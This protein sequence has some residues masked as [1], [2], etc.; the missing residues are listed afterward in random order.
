MADAFG[1]PGILAA[2]PLSAVFQILWSLLVSNRLASGA[3][4]QISDLKE[5]QDRLWTAIGEL[6]EP[7]SQLVISSMGR[8]TLLIE[9]AEPILQATMPT[10]PAPL[11]HPSQ[12]LTSE[13][14]LPIS[15]KSE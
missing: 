13:N 2:P 15:T 1:L 11:F 14:S 5:R 9:K 7:H 4:A 6:D 12:P 8:L 10:E 3:S